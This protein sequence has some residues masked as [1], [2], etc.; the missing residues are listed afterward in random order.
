ML[1]V[2]GSELCECPGNG[3]GDGGL[4]PQGTA[5]LAL[6]MPLH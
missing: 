1:A 4:L 6:N 5:P 2:L 3:G